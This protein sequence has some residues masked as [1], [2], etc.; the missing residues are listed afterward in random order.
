M[1]AIKGILAAIKQKEVDDRIIVDDEAAIAIMSKLLKRGKESIKSYQDAGRQD[2]VDLEQFECD[3]IA[4]YMPV[5]LTEEEVVK[6]I[7]ASI[8][9]LGKVHS[10]F[11]FFA[12][13]TS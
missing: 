1:G 2:L 13:F 4:T 7:E 9:N 8:T 10:I 11:Y 5:Q 6:L 3:M 12:H